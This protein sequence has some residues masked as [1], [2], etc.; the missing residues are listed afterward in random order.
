MLSSEGL[1]LFFKAFHKEN[2]G[3]IGGKVVAARANLSKIQSLYFMFPYDQFLLD[4]EKDLVQQF[5]AL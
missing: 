4:L 3:N 5:C 2:Y 1:S